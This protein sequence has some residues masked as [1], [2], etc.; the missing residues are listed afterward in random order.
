MANNKSPQKQDILKAFDKASKVLESG[1]TFL[2][3]TQTILAMV[4][5]MIAAN[6]ATRQQTEY[7][8]S[9][10]E[11][12]PYEILGVWET[13]S[14]EEIKAIYR[15]KCKFYYPSTLEAIDPNNNTAFRKINEAYKAIK[16]ERG[17]S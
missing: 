11:P 3:S 15:A 17:M 2:N 16:N 7:N 13:A 5:G 10:K 1:S 8:Q 12:T 6:Q 14:N 4:A 9:Q